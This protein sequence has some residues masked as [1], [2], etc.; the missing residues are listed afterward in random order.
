MFLFVLILLFNMFGLHC[1]AEAEAN[2]KFTAVPRASEFQIW[3]SKEIDIIFTSVN[4]IF[5]GQ[6]SFHLDTEAPFGVR[7]C[8]PALVHSGIGI[9]TATSELPRKEMD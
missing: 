8:L 4:F 6:C 2:S 9:Y 3:E 5:H 7:V 1:I